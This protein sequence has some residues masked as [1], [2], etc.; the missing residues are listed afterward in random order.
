MAAKKVEPQDDPVVFVTPDN[1]ADAPT[2][3]VIDAAAAESDRPVRVQVVEPYRVVHEGTA[4]VFGDVA[5]V[6][7]QLAD[8]WIKSGWAQPRELGRK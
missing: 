6:P 1:P 4:Y 3:L 2:G 7:A 5:E 8:E